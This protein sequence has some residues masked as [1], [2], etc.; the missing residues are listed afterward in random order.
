[1]TDS[2]RAMLQNGGRVVVP[3]LIFAL[4]IMFSWVVFHSRL[5]GHPVL[6][7]RVKAL[8]RANTRILESQDE[9][10]D[11]LHEIKETVI[12]IETGGSR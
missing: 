5:P 4:G 7:E 8:D 2:Q 12:R 6:V 3:F 11:D 9:I 1:M 10:I